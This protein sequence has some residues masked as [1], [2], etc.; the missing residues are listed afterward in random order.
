MT[1]RTLVLGDHVVAL[2][3]LGLLTDSG[4]VVQD[5]KITAV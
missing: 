5:E 4:V 3:S 1:T 2:G